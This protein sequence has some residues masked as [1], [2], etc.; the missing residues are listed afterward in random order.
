MSFPGRGP[1]A[2]L[3][4]KD[5]IKPVPRERRGQ[6]LR[7]ITAFFRPYRGQVSVVLVAILLTSFVGLINPILLKLLIDIAIPR[8]DWNL[9]NLFVGL[10]IVLPI[11]SGL[12]GVGQSY[13]NNVI[14]QSVMHDLRTALYSH[15]QMMP[16]RFFTETRTGEIQSRLAN[17][18]GGIQSVV[19]DTAASLTS[20]VAI[21][22]S[23][24][25]AMLIIDWRLTLLSLGL[26]PFFMYLT[27]RVGK[28]NREVRGET[29][30][31]LAEMSATTEET[32]SVSGMLL[33]KTFGQQQ[34]AIARFSKLNRELA[35]LQVRQAMVGRW[36][37][38]IIGTIFSITPAF[39]YWL[40]GYLAVNHDPSA[41]TI[42]DIVA[43]TTLQSRLF[44]P[45]GQLLNVQVEIQ[46][47]LALF[48]R[49]FEY[50]AMDPQIADAPDAVALD[51]HA[52]KGRIRFDHVSFRYPAALPKAT[53]DETETAIEAEA[54]AADVPEAAA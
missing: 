25:I 54:A 28:V 19:T 29:Q 16:H 41:P 33:S 35:V 14:G 36:F 27:F 31:S 2:R 53:E 9:L 47:A 44:F 24:I 26:L 10:M 42:G 3:M 8:R 11:V 34:A 38:M 4:G 30:K 5:G 12:I 13:L 46:G 37:F 23:T 51:P 39:V 22:I 20:N 43:F 15:L 49:I 40:A 1:G 21:A 48:D 7:K 18:V 6:T 52:L 17:D 45:L 50:L 32:L